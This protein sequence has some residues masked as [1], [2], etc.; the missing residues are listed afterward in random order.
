MIIYTINN[1]KTYEIR[2]DK[3]N[4]DW[5]GKADFVVDETVL[6][7]RE[8]VSKIIQ[9]T[10]CFD[11]VTDEEGNLVD[12]VKNDVVVKV[13][14]PKPSPIEVLQDENRTLKA[15]VQALSESNFFL[16]ECLVEMAEIV[17][18]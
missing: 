2:S 7:N 12:V 1:L 3:S 9:L 11:Y 13:P 17:Y 6:E 4:E 10:P 8:L 15:Q 16:E 5:T 14:E 18:A